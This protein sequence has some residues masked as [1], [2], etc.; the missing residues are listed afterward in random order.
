MSAIVVALAWRQF[1]C[2]A[3]GLIYDEAK[4]DADSG[5]APGTRFDDIPDDWA[6]PLCGVTK[7]DFEP[8]DALPLPRRAISASRSVQARASRYDAGIVIVGA[9]RA[10]WQ[11]AQA[12]RE[13]DADASITIVS[14]CAG[15]VYDKPS[16]SVACAREIAPERLVR[17]RAAEAAQRLRVRLLTATHAVSIS[18][19]AKRL[20]TTRGTLHYRH[21]VLAH[22]AAP[23]SVATLPPD[24]CWRINDL[25]AYQ[26]LRVA[27]G[28]RRRHIVIVGAGLV[29]SELA[30]DLA[31]EGHGITLLDV[32]ARPLA[33]QLPALASQRLLGA[34]QG[35]PL[36]F[37]GN[38]QV[39]SVQRCDGMICVTTACGQTFEADQVIAATGLMPAAQLAH[40]AGL[41]V[42]AGGIAV[43]ATTLRSSDPFIFALGDCAS[44]HGR[45]QRYIEPIARQARAIASALL[46]DGAQRFAVEAVPLR[47]KTGSM[48]FTL[49]GTPL[50]DAP[51]TTEVDHDRE[52]RMTQ[53]LGELSPVRLHGTCRDVSIRPSR[54]AA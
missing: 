30:N 52:L 33:A 26:R 32:Q 12:L 47:V 5:L 24:L 14:A 54:L 18:A 46:G 7:A 31:L 1:I 42:D 19:I 9:G 43:D 48:P 17:E 10:G 51:W 28:E 25:A 36:R 37:V 3:C 45:A 50:A 21:L 49:H 4:G 11:T 39:A 40:S 35:L 44:I 29:G 41:A 2:K 27:L 53:L 15:D 38:V 20:R 6:C 8:H 16:L 22:G 23:R 13:L 34:W